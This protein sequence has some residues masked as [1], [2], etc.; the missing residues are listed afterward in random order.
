MD[1][2]LIQADLLYDHWLYSNNPKSYQNIFHFQNQKG[3]IDKFEFGN[4]Y[5]QQELVNFWNWSKSIFP[6]IKMKVIS[7]M[8]QLYEKISEK[9]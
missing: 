8:K 1:T 2:C 6:N 5:E 9:S 7:S 4:K 3:Q